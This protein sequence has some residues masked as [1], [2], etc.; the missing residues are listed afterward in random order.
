MPEVL[1]DLSGDMG[2]NFRR[3]CPDSNLAR[4]SWNKV[5]D[6]HDVHWGSEEAVAHIVVP[7][8]WWDRAF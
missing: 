5:R 7:E 3:E 1:A 2:D 8:S 6:L 4:R